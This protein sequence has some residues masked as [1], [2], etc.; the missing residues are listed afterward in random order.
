MVSYTQL[1]SEWLLRSAVPVNWQVEYD[2]KKGTR[3]LVGWL[4]G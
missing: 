2:D 4:S 1:A 3:A